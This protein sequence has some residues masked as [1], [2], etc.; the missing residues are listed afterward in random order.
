VRVLISGAGV[1]G[2]AAAQGLLATGHEVVVLERG[3]LPAA[4]PSG[5]R[6]RLDSRA[7]RALAR[8]LPAPVFTALL[9]SG[10]GNAVN[11]RLTYLDQRLRP[12]GSTREGDRDAL[13]IGRGPLLRLLSHGI[14]AQVLE[15]RAVRSFEVT[16]KA[17]S[18][19]TVDGAVETGD[20]LVV[21]EGVRSPSRRQ[22]LGDVGY[23]QLGAG[24]I[25]ARVPGRAVDHGLTGIADA[26]A[27]GYALATGRGGFGVFLSAHDPVTGP[28]IDPAAIG[29]VAA[30]VEEP[31]LIWALLG[32]SGRLPSIDADADVL[33]TTVEDLTRS[34][35]PE[36]ARLPA[37]SD[38]TSLRRLHLHAAPPVPVWPTT[39]VTL[40]GDAVHV[41]P[42]TG[43]IGASTAI[44]DA[45]HLVQALDGVNDRPGALR[46]LHHY[47][48]TMRDYADDV[49][50][51]SVAPLR[52]QHRL[53]NPV[54]YTAVTGVR[55]ATFALTGRSLPLPSRN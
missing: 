43:G 35:H 44:R 13:M 48:Q 11:Q 14:A 53:R 28:A 20:V 47:E 45:D 5:F 55:A 41:V 25:S 36:I 4:G 16:P 33:R 24:A 39:A 29:P 31:Y 18:V 37:L 27:H 26:L 1:G 17:V 2:L 50:A 49:V 30:D 40:L 12:L 52:W 46:A 34:W 8:L 6:L 54:L 7:V 22:L 51:G 23:Q 15:R 10:T 9:A 42:P 32:P 21:A 38:P 3:V 19:T